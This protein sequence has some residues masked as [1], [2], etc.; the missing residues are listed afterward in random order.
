MTKAV[1]GAVLLAFDCTDEGDWQIDALSVQC[2]DGIELDIP[3]SDL[4]GISSPFSVVAAEVISDDDQQETK[5]VV[6]DE[7]DEMVAADS[8]EEAAS[9]TGADASAG[10]ELLKQSQQSDSTVSQASFL[11]GSGLVAAVA[12][13]SPNRVVSNH[14]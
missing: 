8:V 14:F 7:N 6:V 2:A 3:L 4:D 12:T 9:I 1:E 10:T 5:A 11:G 13:R